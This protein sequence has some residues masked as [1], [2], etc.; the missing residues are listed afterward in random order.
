MTLYVQCLSLCRQLTTVPVPLSAVMVREVRLRVG[1]PARPRGIAPW[2]HDSARTWLP[3]WTLAR[4]ETLR[5][6]V[7]GPEVS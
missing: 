4:I 5:T 2:W 3:W 1:L 7:R 6:A